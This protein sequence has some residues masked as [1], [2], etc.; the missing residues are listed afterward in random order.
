MKFIMSARGKGQDSIKYDIL[1]KH[2]L[3][4]ITEITKGEGS[5]KNPYLVKIGIHNRNR[6]K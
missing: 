5:A 6:K 2:G 3:G 4:I 1:E